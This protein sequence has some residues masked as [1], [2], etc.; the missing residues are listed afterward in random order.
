M[1]LFRTT[2]L[3]IAVA[4]LGYVAWFNY[5]LLVEAFGSGPPYFGRTTNMDKWRDPRPALAIL[6]AIAILLV[7]VSIQMFRRRAR[8]R[9]A[10]EE[11]FLDGDSPEDFARRTGPEGA[12]DAGEDEL[13]PHLR[14]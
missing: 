12:E 13:G 1:T 10:L 9:A 11:D 5:S 14:R 3:V 7:A 8:E 4:F 6:D 2:G